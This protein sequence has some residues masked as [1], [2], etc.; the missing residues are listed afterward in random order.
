[1][2]FSWFGMR[3]RRVVAPTLKPR[4]EKVEREDKVDLKDMSPDVVPFLAQVAYFE[5]AVFES[6]TR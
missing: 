3:K 2:V 1:M 5:L 4:Q 6:L